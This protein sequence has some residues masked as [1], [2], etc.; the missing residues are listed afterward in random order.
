MPNNEFLSDKILALEK[1]VR[2]SSWLQKTPLL[3]RYYSP[4]KSHP[5]V[6]GETA[7]RHAAAEIIERHNQQTAEDVRELREKYIE[8]AFGIVTV[9]SLVEK[10]AQCIDPTDVHLCAASQQVHV[11]Q[12][13]E[14]MEMDGKATSEMVLAALIHDLG[15]TLLLTDELP[16]NIV[17]MNE[18]I[19][20]YS[21]GIGLDNCIFQWNH[22]EFAYSRLKD[23]VSDGLAWLIRYHSIRP[24]HCEQ[25]MDERDRRYFEE[26]LLPFAHYDHGTKDIHFLPKTRIEDYR[27][28]IEAAFP[29]PILF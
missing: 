14:K 25:Y 18:P 15:K 3:W 1:S 7:Y 6:I 20:K 28:L 2:E 23:Y 21:T 12:I 8:P 11:L 9:W 19:G 5:L 13:I 16:E 29:E 22:D 4:R 27:H 17:G 26:Y 10:L 24:R